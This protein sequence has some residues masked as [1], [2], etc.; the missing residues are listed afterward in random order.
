[1]TARRSSSCWRTAVGDELRLDVSLRHWKRGICKT[2]GVAT[3][4][5]GEVVVTA[6][7]TTV[8]RGVS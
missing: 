1:M 2:R 3:L 4:A 7:L 6:E 8:V 5:T